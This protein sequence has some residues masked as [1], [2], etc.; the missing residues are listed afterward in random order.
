MSLIVELTQLS[1]VQDLPNRFYQI[2]EP[3]PFSTFDPEFVTF[4]IIGMH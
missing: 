3:T 1:R 2:V 4:T